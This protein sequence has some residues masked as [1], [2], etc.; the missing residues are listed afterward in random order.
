MKKNIF[1]LCAFAMLFSACSDIFERQL[2]VYEDATKELEEVKSVSDLLDKAIKT[3]CEIAAVLAWA[4]DEEWQELKEDYEAAEYDVMLDSVDAV[5]DLY[6]R[7][8]DALYK[9]YVMHFV[10]KRVLLYGKV[11]K[12]FAGALYIEEVNALDDFLKRYSAKAY[13]DGQRV[14][15]PPEELREEYASVKALA[16]QNYEEALVR[17]SGE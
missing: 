17:L 10:E 8:V 2:E 7:H 5:R 4:T 9:G 15:D 14:C 12:A 3:E 6:F 16:K 11:A 13:I 1:L